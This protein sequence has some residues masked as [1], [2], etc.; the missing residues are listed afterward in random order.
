[1]AARGDAAG[2]LA[3]FEAAGVTEPDPAEVAE[4]FG[5]AADDVLHHQGG[6]RLG[7]EVARVDVEHQLA[8]THAHRRREVAERKEDAGRGRG[9]DEALAIFRV[10]LAARSVR[11]RRARLLQEGEEV[12]GLVDLNHDGAVALS[13]FAT[14]VEA[15]M[16]VA[17]EQRS[18]FAH[19]KGFDADM[20]LAESSTTI[21]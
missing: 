10:E 14:H 7:G 19:S 20:V 9:L 18:T 1:M 15:D 4:V 16:N 3:L 12:A 2:A 17:E 8:V 21:T 6:P 13:E 5:V 11:P